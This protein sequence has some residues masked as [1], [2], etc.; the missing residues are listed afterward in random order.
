MYPVLLDVGFYRLRSYGV[1]VAIAILTA[2]WF[3]AREARR[4][5]LDPAM[6]TDGSLA[7]VLTGLVGARLYYI[8]FNEPARYLAEPLQVLAVWHGG[9]S[10][11]GG[12]LAGL[13][14]A[15][16]YV[17]RRGLAFWTFADVLTPGLILGQTVG[18]IACLLN[19]DT[20]GRPTTLPW[21]I[22]FT[23][24][25]AMGPVGV[26]LHPI[27]VYELLAYGVVFLIV[28]VVA[29]RGGRGGTVTLTYAVG[30][31]IARF[32]VEFFR[33]DP[34]V[35]A[36]VIVPQALSAALVAVA[37]ATWWLRRPALPA[38]A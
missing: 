12:L 16:W 7:I 32:A 19:G 20:Y 24:P 2:I 15:A 17:R 13:A 25:R 26:P 22:T 1:F 11:H 21:A 6:V 14:A 18:Q 34:P 29:R 3:S 36:G 10:V 35:V 37:A 8:L 38:R 27:Q 23:D 4:R 5:G 28:W 9:L 30:Y 33:G 31:G